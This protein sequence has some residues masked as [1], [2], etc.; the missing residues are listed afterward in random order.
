MKT[1]NRIFAAVIALLIILS[2]ITNIIL[3]KADR[4]DMG[5]P[6]R[7]EVSR[8]ASVIENDGFEDI[9]LSGCMY[10]TD[11]CKYG[12][13]FYDTESDY[14]VR[15]IGG[16]LYRF[17]Y[18]AES[19][20]RR[21]DMIVIVNMILS[22]TAAAVLSIMLYVK[23]RILKPFEKLSNV[24]DELSRGNLT[25]PLKEDRSR[26]FGK[27]I[28]GFNMLRE[29]M[30]Q[31]KQ[32]ELDLQR[33]KKLLLLSLSHDI[34]T[35][36]SAI[37]LYSKALSKEL[38]ESREKQLEIA[39]SINDKA[40]EIDGYVSQII[41]ASREDFLSLEACVGEIYLSELAMRIK[42]YYADKLSLVKIGFSVGDYSDCLLKADLE[43]SVEA[44]QNVMENAIKYGDGKNIAI[45]F[46]EE[47]DCALIT[48]KNSGCTLPDA[49][50]PHIFESFWRGANA[51]KEKGSGLGLYICHQLMHK[52]DGEIFAE[53]KDSCFLATLVF[54]KA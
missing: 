53:I 15:E 52:M 21:T 2:A 46:S 6:Y 41:T 24:P 42:Q 43:R 20:Q 40:D 1:F 5:R 37:K 8:L 30:E 16:E 33:E 23:L 34:K 14:I 19:S 22:I 31:Q 36:L 4:N 49:D 28:W 51:E 32:R 26:F 44:L 3:A 12:T 18:K 35:P 9:D 17:D 25:V 13:G 27:F 29:N 38:Y 47:E 54:R 48:V 10:V 45:I 11:V 50:L 39:E 7:V